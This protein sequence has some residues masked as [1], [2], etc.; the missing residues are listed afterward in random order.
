MRDEASR[1]ER[2]RANSWASLAVACVWGLLSGGVVYLVADVLSNTDIGG[3]GWSLR[4]NGALVV[5]FTLA[6]ALVAAGW[7]WLADRSTQRALLAGSATLAIALLFIAAPIAIGSGGGPLVSIGVSIVALALALGVGLLL[8]GRGRRLPWP[9]IS[10][11]V[12]AVLV[13]AV[14]GMG[15]FLMPI[16]LPMVLTAPLLAR[17]W[18]AWLAL[19]CGALVLTALVGSLGGPY[20]FA[21]SG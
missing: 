13:A 7:V 6:P 9:V 2:S 11:A 19:C 20:L 12:V 4:G 16:L 14:P 15:Y 18:S 21:R 10:V 3:P 1:A 5:P 17:R 8:G